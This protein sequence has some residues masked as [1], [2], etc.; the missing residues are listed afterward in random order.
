MIQDELTIL[1][2]SCDA[3]E[4]LWTPFFTLLK[5]YWNPTSIRILLNTESRS[6]S[7]S[8][9]NIECVH[10]GR[11]LPYGQR[12]LNA[13]S[14]ISTKYVLLLLDDF[15]LRSP[16]QIEKLEQLIQW[17][18]EDPN[19]VYFS[20]DPNK[21]YADWE[22]D[23]YPGFRR[24][25][26]GTPYTLTTQAAI[27]Q[28]DLLRKCWLPNVS[29]WE[30]E[31]Y[32]SVRV[33]RWKTKKFYCVRDS[34]YAFLDYGHYK[35]GDIWGVYRG[36]WYA[37]DVEPLFS[38]EGIVVDLTIR[39]IFEPNASPVTFSHGNMGTFENIERCLGRNELPMYYLFNRYCQLLTLLKQPVTWDYYAFLQDRAKK[40]FLKKKLRR[41]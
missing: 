22:V 17:M 3:Y 40:R 25:P 39:G 32:T 38:R 20:C 16:V 6:F 35:Y 36:K 15:F 26:P 29:P 33:S 2:C 11:D 41:K 30:W 23:K 31:M 10:S 27:W 24:I 4:D 14:H 7:F 18:N 1:V 37:D 34:Q 13:L 8:D 21:V 9:L 28:T 19:I 12:M 5:K